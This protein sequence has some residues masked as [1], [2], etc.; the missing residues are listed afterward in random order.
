MEN[1]EINLW[2]FLEVLA[3]KARFIIGFTA[4]VTILA[5]AIAFVLP[6][7]YSART[8][9]LPP[10]DAGS[11]VGMVNDLTEALTL[12]SG[13]EQPV[14]A[15]PA[16][17]Y[18]RI[19]KSRTLLRKIIDANGLRKHYGLKSDEDIMDKME[20]YYN[21]RVTDEGL[22]E[23]DFEDKDP[24]LAAQVANSFASELDNLNQDIAVSRAHGLREMLENRLAEVGSSLDSA[25]SAIEDFQQNHRAV[26]IDK[27]T[28]LAIESAVS[29]KVA[30]ADAEINLNVKRK[31]LSDSHPEVIN[32]QRKI[33]EIK[34][35]INTLEFGGADS[36]Y[37]NLPVAE[38]PQLKQDYA[39]LM[40]DIKTYE[41]LYQLISQQYEQ[42]KIQSRMNAPTVAVIDPAYVPEKP[43]KPRKSMIVMIA[44]ALSLIAAVFLALIM[45][46]ISELKKTSPED[47]DRA[48][49]FLG[50]YFFWLPGIKRAPRK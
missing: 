18:V 32:L 2:K 24:R 37:F 17:I 1:K 21:V 25:R 23:I 36:S 50:T 11:Y 49:V 40:A 19:L 3:I 7:W 46:Y 45:N 48:S 38:V 5:V 27:Q 20:K 12:T 15:T 43:V 16:D 29:L 30:L 8:L 33:N 22:I 44:F 6:K 41:A 34:N 14:S 10:K 28:E 35:Q 39:R 47:Y 4:V 13:L 31:T 42:V 9:L 26:D